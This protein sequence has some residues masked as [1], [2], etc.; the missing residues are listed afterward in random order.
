MI[1]PEVW[2]PSGLSPHCSF[3]PQHESSLRPET[4][5]FSS[6]VPNTTSTEEAPRECCISTQ[7]NKQIEWRCKTL[8]KQAHLSGVGEREP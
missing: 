4:L 1:A 8:F 2:D 5:L 7:I 3:T 6:L